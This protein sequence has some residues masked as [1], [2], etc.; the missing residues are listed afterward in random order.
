VQLSKETLLEIHRGIV[1]TRAR[2]CLELGT[3]FGATACVMAAA[4]A[5]IGGGTVSSVDHITRESINW[6]RLRAFPA[7]STQSGAARNT[8]G[9]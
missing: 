2:D 6:R 8:I 3:G 9:P 1:G 7:I 5:E 4:V